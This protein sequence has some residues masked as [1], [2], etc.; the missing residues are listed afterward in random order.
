MSKEAIRVYE[1]TEI[2]VVANEEEVEFYVKHPEVK[3][4]CKGKV[5]G[6]VCNA[7]MIIVRGYEDLK[8]EKFRHIS[9]RRV[10]HLT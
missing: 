10:A 9:S 1:G 2:P 8:V 4:F 3:Y 6:K 7:Q 5:L